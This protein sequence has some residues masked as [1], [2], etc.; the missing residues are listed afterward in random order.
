VLHA[1]NVVEIVLKN[2]LDF[3]LLAF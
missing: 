3:A 2:K 1:L